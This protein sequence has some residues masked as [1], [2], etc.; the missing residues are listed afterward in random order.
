V[1]VKGRK[2]IDII[3]IT[4]RSREAGI[5]GKPKSIIY[6]NDNTKFFRVKISKGFKK[7]I[8]INGNENYLLEV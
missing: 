3:D 6:L 7:I 4:K 2:Q 1:N 8:L 5:K